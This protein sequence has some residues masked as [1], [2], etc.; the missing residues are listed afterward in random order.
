M[1]QIVQV[2]SGSITR[3]HARKLRDS[4]QALVCAIQDRVGDDTRTIEGFQLEELP[5]VTLLVA[6]E[7][8]QTT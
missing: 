4:L 8:K 6:H 1:N 3:A 5:C 7:E 2:P